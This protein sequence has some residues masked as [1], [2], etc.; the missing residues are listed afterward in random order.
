[1]SLYELTEVLWRRRRIVGVAALLLAV[2]GSVT[3]MMTTTDARYVARGS[4]IVDQ[5]TLF[6]TSNGG[7]VA[8]KLTTFLPTVCGLL[9]GD[10]AV[11]AISSQTGESAASVRSLV[12][13]TP[14]PSTT[15][16]D[17][18]VSTTNAKRSQ[19]VTAA[20]ADVLVGEIAHRY[21]D[22]AVPPAQRIQASVLVAPP[23]PGRQSSHTARQIALVLVGSVLLAAAFAVAAE[24]HRR[25]SHDGVWIDLATSTNGKHPHPVTAGAMNGSG[26][27]GGAQGPAE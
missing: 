8:S 27:V 16:T 5:P 18:H 22:P 19:R 10:E 4:V 25:D 13:C 15:I 23:V 1:M 9:A 2:I 26:V 21:Q 17:L 11:G 20:A 24:P 6:G 7:D 3:V 12:R 14:R